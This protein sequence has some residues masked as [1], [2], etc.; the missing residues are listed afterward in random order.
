MSNKD[1]LIYNI[2]SSV[3]DALLNIKYN[4]DDLNQM[5]GKGNNNYLQMKVN[6]IKKNVLELEKTLKL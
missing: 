3:S 4:L 1:E 5:N 6:G 2:L